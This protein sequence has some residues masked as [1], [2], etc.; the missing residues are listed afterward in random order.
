MR[1]V[2]MAWE[3]ILKEELQKKKDYLPL[4]QPHYY[5]GEDAYF[6][7]WTERLLGKPIKELK[8]IIDQM[9]KIFTD[10]WTEKSLKRINNLKEAAT[11]SL[12]KINIEELIENWQKGKNNGD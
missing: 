9:E 12:E 7:D 2:K 6:S 3:K 8:E 4:D 1:V 11:K 5:I 10:E